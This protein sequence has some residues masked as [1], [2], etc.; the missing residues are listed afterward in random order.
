MGQRRL[1]NLPASKETL[2][3]N[4]LDYILR[5]HCGF[6]EKICRGG[7]IVNSYWKGTRFEEKLDY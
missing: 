1:R 7:N 5:K 6:L 2:L 4:E 3:Y